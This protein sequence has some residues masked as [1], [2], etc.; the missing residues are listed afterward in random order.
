MK[1]WLL[2]LALVLVVALGS[3]AALASGDKNHGDVGTGAVVI[4]T[5]AEGA[6]AQPRVGR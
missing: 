5:E 2:I 6:A 3:L 1:K 4:G